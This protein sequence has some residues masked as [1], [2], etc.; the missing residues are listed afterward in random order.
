MSSHEK[1]EQ[2]VY[3]GNRNDINYHKRSK[4][5][6]KKPALFR[7]YFWRQ[8]YIDRVNIYLTLLYVRYY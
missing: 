6:R 2:N 3:E 7:K 5:M 4:R 1:I 8:N